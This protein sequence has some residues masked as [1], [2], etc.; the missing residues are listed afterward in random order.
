MQ[1]SQCQLT[2]F[3]LYQPEFEGCQNLNLVELCL[4]FIGNSRLKN[5][6]KTNRDKI[7]ES[8]IHVMNLLKV[9]LLTV[10]GKNKTKCKPV[11]H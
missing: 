1:S 7:N 10:F 11:N 5:L 8:K 6:Q 9:L 3:E 2:L 4:A